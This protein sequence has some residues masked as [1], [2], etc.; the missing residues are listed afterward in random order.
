MSYYWIEKAVWGKGKPPPEWEAA[1]I[2]ETLKKLEGLS[3]D[4]S[5]KIER[6]GKE[7][8]EK[9]LDR[10]KPVSVKNC[11]S[12]LHKA[13]RIHFGEETG[14]LNE[15]NSILHP[16]RGVREHFACTFIDTP[17]EIKR[18]NIGLQREALDFKQHSVGTIEDPE[19][20]VRR[21]S[22]II[23]IEIAAYQEKGF[24]NYLEIGA[25][26]ALVVGLRPGEILRDAVL[27]ECSDYTV[28]LVQGQAKTR[29]KKRVYEMPT[30]IEAAKVM[31]AY[32]ILRKTFK[33]EQ[34]ND[35]E[36]EPYKNKLRSAVEKNFKE[37]VP[38][39]QR[40]S[41]EKA[42]NP[43]RLRAVYDAIAVFY[44]CP[45]EIK[46]FAYI[47]EING[48]E[49]TVGKNDAA[50]HYL[51]YQIG[52]G[53]IVAH[54]GQRQGIKLGEPGV[55]V[56]DAIANKL[57]AMKTKKPTVSEKKVSLKINV[58]P[59]VKEEFIKRKETIKASTN[60]EALMRFLSS[61]T[62]SKAEVSSDITPEVLGLSEEWKKRLEAVMKATGQT[63][64]KEMICE[65]LKQEIKFREGMRSRH[66]GK[67]FES[68]PL[69][70]LKR[71][72]HPEAA[73]EKMRRAFLAIKYHNSNV[74]TEKAQRWYINANSIHRLVGGRFTIITPWVEAH[75]DEIESHNQTYELTEGDNRK[76]VSITDVITVPEMPMD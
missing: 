37:I 22:E 44:Y 31:E 62:A 17:D 66:E 74:A 56:I 33:A 64:L 1:L 41:G 47:K 60:E 67:D 39:L 28:K 4:E 7:I 59:Q 51:D 42:V 5:E 29:G 3:K 40:M 45:E 36:L 25:A 23:E 15:K 43:Q 71:T 14:R 34:L 26:L 6:I 57:K 11:F 27:E 32:R 50:M 61:D 10:V 55:K 70:E 16:T 20:I 38:T 13:I 65:L 52:N 72:R 68:M 69:S 53:A 2:D 9:F 19:R 8:T 54:K 73:Q 18:E 49:P 21:A 24:S 75:I 63:D 35:K 12:R 30:L 58:T 46:D 76:S 48:H